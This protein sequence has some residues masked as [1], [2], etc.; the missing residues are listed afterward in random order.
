MNGVWPGHAQASERAYEP[1]CLVVAEP[2][3]ARI[4]GAVLRLLAEAMLLI[5]VAAVAGVAQFRPLVIVA[6]MAAAFAAVSAC[7]WAASRSAFVPPVFGF[8]ESLPPVAPVATEETPPPEADP[9]E[10][11]FVVQSEPARP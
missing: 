2:R 11:G 5:A 1:T 7:E 6:L 4:P 8:V 3:S 10:R 9:W